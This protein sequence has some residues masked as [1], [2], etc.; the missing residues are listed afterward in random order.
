M[1]ERTPSDAEAASALLATHW[2]EGRTLE[3]LPPELRPTTR[4]EGY[5][6]QASIE[7]VS[8]EPL[9][10]WKIAAT[11]AAGQAHINVDGPLAG[12]LLAERIVPEGMPV[13]L[14]ANRMRV[15]EIEFVFRMGRTLPAP[16]RDL[17]RGRGDGRRRGAAPRHR[18][19]GFPI[20]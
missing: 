11:S 14:A 2:R 20:P 4:A 5:A 7:S 3:A 10:G 6:I 16:R 18:S 1:V 8:A 13:R 19:A 9:R 12:R 15:A 17:C